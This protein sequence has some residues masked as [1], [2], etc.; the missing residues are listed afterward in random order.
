M[1]KTNEIENQS[2]AVL[3]EPALRQ[4]ITPIINEALDAK[5]DDELKNINDQLRQIKGEQY[6][7][8]P[9]LA[10]ILGITYQ[11]VARHVR[12]GKLK[13]SKPGKNYIVNQHQVDQY[14]AQ[15]N[16]YGDQD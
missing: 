8:L 1:M 6:Y 3:L 12:E 14:L 9:E 4:I 13:A 11:T 15:T 2:L 10:T 5:L 7:T 16:L